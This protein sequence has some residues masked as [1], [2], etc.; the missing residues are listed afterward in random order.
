[1]EE[2]KMNLT[3]EEKHNIEKYQE[4]AKNALASIGSLRRQ[5]KN[6][7]DGLFMQLEKVES[8]LM[9]Y[10]KMLAK[11]RGMDENEDWIFDPNNFCFVKK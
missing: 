6:S 10:L 9:N 3:I 5:F 4:E 2:E 7:E 1:M 8:E 11:A